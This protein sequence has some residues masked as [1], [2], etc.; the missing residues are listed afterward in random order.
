MVLGVKMKSTKL[1]ML[2]GAFLLSATIAN[3]ATYTSDGSC[4]LSNVDPAASECFG[5]ADGNV[6]QVDVNN[7]T[8]GSDLGLFG[9]RDW[10]TIQVDEA[11]QGDG[12]FDVGAHS[13][14]M[15]AILLKSADQFSAYLVNEWF[16]GTLEYWTANKNDLS[17][18]TIVGRSPS[19]IP[20]PAAGWLLIAGLGGLAAM[21]RRAKA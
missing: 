20:V 15:V 2:A 8:F 14:S 19:Q 9:H 13:Y 17:N 12:S 18:Y 1:A 16:G 3:A 4:S 11:F 7:D 21:R 5:L 6:Q 10:V